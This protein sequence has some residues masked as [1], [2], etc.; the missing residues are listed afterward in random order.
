[1]K[2]LPKKIL[3]VRLGAL[4]DVV[5]ALVLANA[6]KRAAPETFIGWAVHN[7]AYPI[8]DG[9][10]AVDRAHLW[11][12]KLGARGILA[13]VREVREEGYDLAIDL[14][15][16]FK[17]AA[18]ARLS[19]APR[20]L[21]FDK[22]RTKEYAGLFLKER[23]PGCKQTLSPVHMVEQYMEFASYL[24]I[25]GA[26]K[27]SLP[28]NDSAEL[29]AEAQ[30]KV[31]GDAPIAIGIGASYESKR[32]PAARFLELARRAS[33]K[34][35]RPVILLGGPGDREMSADELDELASEGRAGIVDYVGKTSLAEL[36]A[37]TGKASV[38]VSCDT[39]PMHLA[40]AKG[41]RVVALFGPGVAGRTGPY[42]P[43]LPDGAGRRHEIISVP[44][45]CAPCNKRT[46]SMDRHHCML[47]IGVELVLAAVERQ[48][49]RAC[50]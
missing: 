29:W 34:L 14:A 37:I 48:L 15:R 10:P 16:I 7:L 23:I 28:A 18:V 30:I 20:V 9:N 11:D 5:N 3:I 38:F 42:N 25:E 27:H 44:P 8:V 21:G 46:C 1:M 45:E 24:G 26:P 19:G 4:G 31:L 17:S 49:A 33:D 50:E 36:I 40:V 2:P 32:W 47:D 6:I 13:C 39:G 35:G 41:R 22:K 12:K 43:E